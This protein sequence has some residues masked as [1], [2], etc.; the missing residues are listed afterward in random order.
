MWCAFSP[1]KL[2]TCSVTPALAA[3]AMKN[4]LASVVSNVPMISMG[5]ATS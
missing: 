3:S 5:S 2:R 1:E 4:S